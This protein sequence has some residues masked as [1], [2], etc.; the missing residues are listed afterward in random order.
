MHL[1]AH[2]WPWKFL[3][4]WEIFCYDFKPEGLSLNKA[5]D[6][7][8]QKFKQQ[9][10]VVIKYDLRKQ[11]D[12]LYV[13]L[14]KTQLWNVLAFVVETFCLGISVPHAVGFSPF[15]QS[16]LKFVQDLTDEGKND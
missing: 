15:P 9:K 1:Q 4:F 12:Q 6:D 2:K 8:E 13:H 11:T 16:N 5:A 14:K 10:K 7:L 3:R